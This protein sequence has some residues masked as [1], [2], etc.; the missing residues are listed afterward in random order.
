MKTI[1]IIISVILVVGVGGFAIYNSNSTST[2]DDYTANDQIS[3]AQTEKLIEKTKPTQP[4]TPIVEKNALNEVVYSDSGYSPAE[5]TIKKGEAVNFINKSKIPLWT[6]SNPHPQHTDLPGFD[7]AE[8]LN[9]LPT[10]SENFS[11]TFNKVGRWG[12]HN[13]NWP[14]HTGFVIVK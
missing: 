13:H 4:E 12:Y 9:R 2:S 3:K 8:V 6:A 1:Y 5:I 10:L 7:T 11:Y 14:A